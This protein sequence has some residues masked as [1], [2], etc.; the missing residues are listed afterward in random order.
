VLDAD[1]KEHPGATAPA[2][3]HAGSTS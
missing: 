2:E 1:I 3:G